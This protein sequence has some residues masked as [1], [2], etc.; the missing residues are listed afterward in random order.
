MTNT[1]RRYLV[2]GVASAPGFTGTTLAV[3]CKHLVSAE[4]LFERKVAESGFDA[5]LLIDREQK[6]VLRS[7]GSTNPEGT[8]DYFGW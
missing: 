3:L 7:F 1:P 4:R 6:K 8:A 2:R 5:V